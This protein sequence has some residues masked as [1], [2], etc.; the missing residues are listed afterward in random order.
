MQQEHL[1]KT[2]KML[3][4]SYINLATT[5]ME[6]PKPEKKIKLYKT[7]TCSKKNPTYEYF[8]NK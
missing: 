3:L 6:P 2:Q 5:A 1:E 8:I 4:S 7:K